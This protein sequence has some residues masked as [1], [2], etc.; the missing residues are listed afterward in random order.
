[1]YWVLFYTYRIHIVS[2]GVKIQQA[3]NIIQVPKA[4]RLSKPETTKK[5]ES[6]DLPEGSPPVENKKRK[7]RPERRSQSQKSIKN[8]KKTKID[9]VVSVEEDKAKAAKR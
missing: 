5:I 7:E 2:P 6:T 3:Y 8:I 1:M 4:I 9:S